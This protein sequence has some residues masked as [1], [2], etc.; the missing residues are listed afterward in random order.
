MVGAGML[1][2]AGMLLLAGCAAVPPPPEDSC[3]GELARQRIDFVPVTIDGSRGAGCTVD[4]PVRISRIEAALNH[5]TVMS[6]R[7]ASR[8]DQFEHDVVQPLAARD[9]GRQVTAIEHFGAYSCRA[10]SSNRG[11]LSEHAL[12]RAIDISGFR[13][14]DGS[15]ANIER[16]WWRPGP[17]R[18]FLHHLAYNA[19]TYF[20]VVLTP[21]SNRDH[22][23][24]LHFD[25][26]PERLCS[27]V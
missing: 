17:Y 11:R 23:N 10:N 16:D 26:G 5:P 15:E 6:C 24:H 12:G 21:S 18:D 8:L 19:C 3:L 2:L 13:F 22:Y 20:S 4:S 1:Q 25:I 7:M 27:G 9:L 14:S